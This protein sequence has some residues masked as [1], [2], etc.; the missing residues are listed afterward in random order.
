MEF[1]LLTY[2]CTLLH[3]SERYEF[4]ANCLDF[5]QTLVNRA[6]KFAFLAGVS[7][8]DVRWK[9]VGSESDRFSQKVVFWATVAQDW[10]LPADSTATVDKWDAIGKVSDDFYRWSSNLDAYLYREKVNTFT[11][12]PTRP[13]QNFKQ[14]VQ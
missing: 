14:L 5:A 13:H 12:P 11:R 3:I 8:R 7:P 6:G 2:D 9:L 10:Q 4:S 1:V